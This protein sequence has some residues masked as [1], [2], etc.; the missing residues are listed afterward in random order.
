[1]FPQGRR[2]LAA[3]SRLGDYWALTKPE[4]NVRILITT[5]AGFY[6]GCA[7]EFALFKALFGTLLVASGTATLNQSIERDFDAQMRRTARRPL[8]AHRLKPRVILVVGIA[9][10][11]AGIAHVAVTSAGRLIALPIQTCRDLTQ[12]FLSC[13]LRVSLSP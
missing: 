10:S 1:M 8:T 9:L 2:G 13:A 11:V 5:F 7:S 3:S 4:V 12:R 6:L